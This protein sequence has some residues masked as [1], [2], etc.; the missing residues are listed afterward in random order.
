MCC[1]CDIEVLNDP[2][3]NATAELF[4][5]V[6][7]FADSDDSYEYVHRRLPAKDAVDAAKRLTETVGARLGTTKR[8]IITDTGDLTVF[9][10]QFGKGVTF[11]TPEQRAAHAAGAT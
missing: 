11:P 2:D 4:D 10:W 9:E 3:R 1:L 5:V 7:F 6:Q 8:V